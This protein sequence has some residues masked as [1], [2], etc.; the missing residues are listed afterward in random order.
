MYNP[1]GFVSAARKTVEI[2]LVTASTLTSLH[3]SKPTEVVL[4]AGCSST[5]L[6]MSKPSLVV[7]VAPSSLTPLNV[8][9]IKTIWVLW[10][11][12]DH[13]SILSLRHRAA[14]HTEQDS[15]EED[16][17]VHDRSFLDE[18]SEDTDLQSD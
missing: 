9:K 6:R 17:G 12:L 3:M 13:L 14:C 15:K 18:L 5:Q 7:L 16:D 2:V 11:S 1:F 8:S 4:V 10:R